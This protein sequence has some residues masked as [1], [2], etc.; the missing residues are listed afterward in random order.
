MRPYFNG[1]M[2]KETEDLDFELLPFFLRTE[3]NSRNWPLSFDLPSFSTTPPNFQTSIP[4]ASN[5]PRS[6][7][8]GPNRPPTCR[9]AAKNLWIFDRKSSWLPVD[10]FRFNPESKK[11]LG[12]IWKDHPNISQSF[13]SFG[14]H[15]R[16]CP[17]GGGLEGCH[18]IIIVS[19][20][21]H[22]NCPLHFWLR[23]NWTL[24]TNHLNP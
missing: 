18:M 24:F 8:T 14:G 4:L 3:A 5:P 20:F 16:D 7:C 22:W 21:S 2:A 19:M 13:F 23:N 9:D 1:E 11:S 17:L 6:Q 12:K 10:A 15:V